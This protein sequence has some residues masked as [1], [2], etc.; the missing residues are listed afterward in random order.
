[1]TETSNS[2]PNHKPLVNEDSVPPTADD[3]RPADSLTSFSASVR[4]HETCG[5]ADEEKVPMWVTHDSH[6]VTARLNS[7]HRLDGATK[8]MKTHRGSAASADHV[9]TT[10]TGRSKSRSPLWCCVT[11]RRKLTML[12]RT[13]L[14]ST[15][16]MVAACLV[17]VILLAL[18]SEDSPE[19]RN[20]TQE[21]CLTAD[22]I[23]IA[24]SMIN[25][26]DASVEPCDDFYRY[27]CGN[28][29]RENVLPDDETGYDVF[30]I[31][32]MK[33]MKKVKKLVEE[34][35]SDEDNIATT[36][37]KQFYVSCTNVDQAMLTLRRDLYLND[38]NAEYVGYMEAYHRFMVDT[39]M[40]LGGD[41]HDRVWDEMLA[42]LELEKEI[43]NLTLPWMEMRGKEEERY[44]KLTIAELQELVPQI[45]WLRLFEHIFEISPEIVITEDEELIVK[46][47]EFMME[48]GQLV[49]NTPKRTMANYIIWRFVENTI[50]RL[51]QRFHDLHYVF[52]DT[53]YK[54]DS[55]SRP[56]W[57]EC[58]FNVVRMMDMAVGSMYIREHFHMEA[59]GHV[60]DIINTIV[61]A[62]LH[63]LHNLDWADEETKVASEEKAR[64]IEK[65]IGYPDE[66][67]DSERLGQMYTW[68][69]VAEDTFFGNALNLERF[70]AKEEFSQLRN[71]VD[72]NKGISPIIHPNA[73]YYSMWNQIVFL[74]G[75]LQPPFY[76]W[77]APKYIN[78]SG[79]GIV[80]GHEI[81]HGFD[82]SGRKYDK[83][84]NL[85]EWW[86]EQDIEAFN[87]K[88]KCIIDQYSEYNIEDV[89]SLNGN[90]TL[91]E[92]IA[93][94]GALK[95]AFWAYRQQIGSNSEESR[96]PGLDLS[97]NQLFFLNYAQL[98]CE[99][100]SKE[101]FEEA[102]KAD[103]H[104]PGEYR[105]IGSLTN[106]KEFS[107]LYN[108]ALGTFMNPEEKCEVWVTT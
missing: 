15:I 55:K 82:D 6:G 39:V 91:G 105:V 81:T 60:T 9:K 35:I 67:M 86:P 20:A 58:V 48:I 68:L 96:L 54:T 13:L 43:A 36:K 24:A 50:I 45:H 62:F 27:A 4:S 16:T 75:I 59:K 74:A 14:V 69:H 10:T 94:N 85:T 41:D 56:R 103:V 61:E 66:V 5:A 99:M 52:Y 17:L 40:L 33:N 65:L 53:L 42:V 108:C 76:N 37:V 80:I 72:R 106:S 3:G 31:L 30:Y 29:L 18:G 63:F 93:D 77:Y 46:S 64:A 8:S 2:L 107:E 104:S 26:M 87:E 95:Q 51:D 98:F 49:L 73:Y 84:G 101:G 23:N 12:E 89:G 83:N 71:P 34:P 47:V 38:S 25:R 88:A 44:N 11:R 1:M 70:L 100:R 78:Y 92:N 22:C 57:R 90:Y 7:E 97:P 102:I 21:I 79:I 19:H 28:W 32:T